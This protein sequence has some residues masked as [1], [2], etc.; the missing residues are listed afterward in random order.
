[1]KLIENSTRIETAFSVLLEAKKKLKEIH[2]EEA[3]TDFGIFKHIFDAAID[4][5]SPWI[6]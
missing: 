2:L 3:T 5:L 4:D 6:F 1:M